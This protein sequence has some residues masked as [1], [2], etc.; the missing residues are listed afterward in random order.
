MFILSIVT[1]HCT[2]L[3]YS[4]GI[5]KCWSTVQF[6]NRNQ[7]NRRSHFAHAVDSHHPPGG[8][9]M[10]P[11]AAWRLTVMCTWCAQDEHVWDLIHG[12]QPLLQQKHVTIVS[13]LILTPINKISNWSSHCQWLTF[14]TNW[15]RHRASTSMYSL[16]FAF[17]LCCQNATSGSQQSRPLQ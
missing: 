3:G 1:I 17:A 7:G 6:T 10:I 5:H 15:T 9:E 14:I 11:S 2:A 4:P 8:N 13:P 12:R 16:T